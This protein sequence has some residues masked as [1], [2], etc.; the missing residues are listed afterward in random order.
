MRRDPHRSR[1]AA[2]SRRSA[3]SSGSLGALDQ[4]IEERL[5]LD[6]VTAGEEDLLEL[7]H[8]EDQALAGSQPAEGEP[9]IGAVPS[10][11]WSAPPQPAPGARQRA[12][13]LRQGPLARAHHRLAQPSEPG[14]T[15]RRAREQAH[16]H[17]G[18]LPAPGGADYGQQ[19]RAD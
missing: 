10:S 2:R 9:V 5:A 16:P 19:R 4:S 18:G 6:R 12:Q 7:V 13:K 1:R 14:T 17:G 3:G 15:R 8:E 11:T